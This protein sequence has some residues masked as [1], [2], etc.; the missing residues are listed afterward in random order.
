MTDRVHSLLVVLD[1]DIRTDE[2]EA[3]ANAIRQLRGVTSVAGNIVDI[4]SKI[5]EERALARVREQIRD[6]LWPT[7]DC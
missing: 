3:L 5:A 4:Q 1:H 7:T 2:V 6:L